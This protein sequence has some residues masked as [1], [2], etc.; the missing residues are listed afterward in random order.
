MGVCLLSFVPLLKAIGVELV[1]YC[2]EVLTCKQ[3]KN[4][5]LKSDNKQKQWKNRS[6]NRQSDCTLGTV[7]VAKRQQFALS[8]II[9]KQSK[10]EKKINLKTLIL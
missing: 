5:F 10:G 6:V 9:K 8:L 7:Y 2:L 3:T 4:S 1:G